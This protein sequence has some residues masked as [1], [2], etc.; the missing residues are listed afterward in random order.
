MKLVLVTLSSFG[1]ST[2]RAFVPMASSSKT[3][4]HSTVAPIETRDLWLEEEFDKV[5]PTD[6]LLRF[7]PADYEK[8]REEDYD[9]FPQALVNNPGV[10]L[11]G[12]QIGDSKSALFRSAFDATITPVVPPAAPSLDSFGIFHAQP[13][14]TPKISRAKTEWFSQLSPEPVANI[15]E[16]MAALSRPTFEFTATAAPVAP[17]L[18]SFKVYRAQPTAG[19]VPFDSHTALSRPTFDVTAVAAPAAPSLESLS[20]YHSQPAAVPK[21]S[22]SQAEWFSQSVPETATATP[23][24]QLSATGGSE[25]FMQ[26]IH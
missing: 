16:S 9:W 8:S 21:I 24:S 5:D 7:D 4:L 17:S 11:K 12:R 13:S 23:H 15:K 6:I 3:T 2:S 1:F 19:L 22:R 26:A 25:W 14:V 18:D 10:N 20:A